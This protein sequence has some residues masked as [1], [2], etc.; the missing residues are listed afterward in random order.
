M[1]EFFIIAC[2]YSNFQI[3]LFIFIVRLDNFFLC[4][5]KTSEYM[6]ISWL[7]QIDWILQDYK[8]ARHV[9]IIICGIV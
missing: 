2:I 5:Q 3:T 7:F 4:R 9:F 1:N 6:T 8:S